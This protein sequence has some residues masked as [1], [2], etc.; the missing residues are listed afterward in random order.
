MTSILRIDPLEKSSNIVANDTSTFVIPRGVFDLSTLKL[1]FLATINGASPNF[2]SLPRDVETM[3]ETLQVFVGDR[4]VQNIQHY[5][6]LFR[7]IE[8]FDKDISEHYH[9]TVLSNSAA[10]PSGMG[11]P[12]FNVASTQYCANKWL[13]IL[14]CKKIIDTNKIGA[15]RIV[16]KW[17]PDAVIVARVGSTYRLDE[18]YFTVKRSSLDEAS[19]Q[20]DSQSSKI[21][22]IE[23]DD[24]KTFI[25]FNNSYMQTIQMDIKSRKLDYVMGM[26]LP[27]DYKTADISLGYSTYGTSYYFVHGSASNT[28]PTITWNFNINGRNLISYNPP[29]EQYIE[30][31]DDL[32][33]NG[34]HLALLPY[35]S[36]TYSAATAA[37]LMLYSWTTGVKTDMD[38][39]EG[40]N[41][42]FNTYGSINVNNPNFSLLV[43]KTSSLLTVDQSGG[44]TLEK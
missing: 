18:L 34:Y 30:Y 19:S 3:I 27:E 44:Y 25:Q 10:I 41:L 22:R 15:I 37:R 29:A 40:I 20:I 21:Q 31:M 8:D 39:S 12:V 17:A 38:A 26:F 13:G 7:T 2:M 11:N 42:T 16:I 32:F 6:Q 24:F 33:T 28:F 23:F 5:N 1:W 43:V 9:R 36:G 14:G 4:E 35:R